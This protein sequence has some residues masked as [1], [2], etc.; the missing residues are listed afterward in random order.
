MN[1][2]QCCRYGW[3][4]ARVTLL[5]AVAGCATPV[6]RHPVPEGLIDNV[7]VFEMPADIRGWG[8]RPSPTLQR[9]LSTVGAQIAASYDKDNEPRDV[10]AISGGGI[11]GS[12]AAGLLCGWT[13]AGNRPNFRAVT[14][15]S[16]GAIL[17]PI[18]YLGPAYDDR[19]RRF[20]GSISDDAVYHMKGLLPALTGDSLAD[21]AP[22]VHLVER[23]I[24]EPLLRAVAA[25]H[26]KGRR[27]FVVTT[28]L[29][30]DRP[31]IWDLGA[32]AS[33]GSPRA[34]SVFR[35]VIV[36]SA[37]MPVAFPPSYLEVEHQGRRY[38]E[39]HVDGGVTGQ[40]VLYGS[41]LAPTDLPRPP[42]PGE[43]PVTYY[44]IRNG[45]LS[46][47]WDPVRPDLRSIATHS[48]NRLIQAQGAGDLWQTYLACRRDGLTFRL[49]WVPNDVVLP[50]EV[51]FDRQTAMALFERGYSMA[52]AGYP[53]A[54][55]PPGLRQAP[56]HASTAP[57]TV[58]TPAGAVTPPD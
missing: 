51:R 15:V 5:V 28:N 20:I 56:P 54:D 50:A 17:A 41:A 38:D 3:A 2:N 33:S 53:W 24:D 52:K 42:G 55:Q 8:D 6:Y 25:E 36:A 46:T 13:A 7:N 30:T 47:R 1:T 32:I 37:A 23:T 21:N 11:N 9:S 44:V 58:A 35:Q 19:L 4:L 48:L 16:V 14:G 57:G 18:A 45:Q 40:V 26:A 49:A 10:L 39:M 27:L 31:V 12:F 43:P 29:D 34:L 22:L